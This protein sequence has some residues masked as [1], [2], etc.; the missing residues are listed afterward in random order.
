MQMS[1]EYVKVCTY[2]NWLIGNCQAM[3]M[4]AGQVS[5]L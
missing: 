5:Q 2:V 1:Y 3:V 4:K